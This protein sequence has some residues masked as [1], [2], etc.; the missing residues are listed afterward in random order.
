MKPKKVTIWLALVM[1]AA[2][3][4]AACAPAAP[5]PAPA[6]PTEA[7][8]E[9]PT[10]A[11]ADA[12][13]GE[14]TLAPAIAERV[15]SG[16]PLRIYVSYHD[17]SNEF[18]PFL[19]SGV[20]KAAADLGVEARFVGPVGA[21]AEQQIAELENLVESGV[22]GLAISSV[23]TDALAPIINR[24]LEQG[25]PVVTYNTDNPDSKRLAFAGQDLEQ[26]GYEA[27]KVLA[28]LLG[29]QGDV[30]ITTLDAAAQWS[31]D[32]ETGARRAFAEYPGIKVLTTVNTGT[33]PQEIYAA[34]ENAMLAN[35]TVTGVLSLEC[36]STPADGE[37]V[38]RNSLQGQV[39]VVGFDELP[40]TL[41]LIKDG[42]VAASISQAPDRQGF[43]AVR[44]L[45][46]FLKGSPIADV[47][48]GVGIINQ[49]NVD[50]YLTG[51]APAAAPAASDFVLAPAIAERVASGQPLRIYVS[52]HDVSNEFAP[53]LK[54]GVEKAAADLGV[55][56]R[57]VGPVGADAEQ[58]IAELENLVESGVD[59]LAISSVSTDALAPII[60]RFLEQGIPVVTYNT[61]NPD[62]K[63]L[64]FAGQ[65]LE[66][67]GYEA[68][69][70]LADLLGGQGDVIITTLDAAAQWSIDRETGAR[71]AFAEYP[72]IKVLTTVNTGTEPQEIYAAVEN[73]MLA[74]PTVTGVLS[75]ECCSTPADGEYVKRNSLQ[76]QVTVV[77][78]DELPATL[79]L[80]KDGYVAA[81]ISQAPDRQGFEAV[82]MLVDFL[83]GSPIADV[84][85]GVGIINQDNVDQYLK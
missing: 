74:N 80:I 3:L 42:Y 51:E 4:L 65:D 20:E 1:V 83:K 75:L 21:D 24:F 84:D 82:R 72:G 15:A 12:A 57:F 35:P 18:A 10:E 17:V 41:D 19:K 29:G 85:T 52:Y 46:D 53:F 30:I 59:G 7:A 58:Q 37:Y 63:R 16:Q 34:V 38:K 69:K 61:D 8:A 77:G 6:E 66:Q 64:A 60:N 78:F 79:D 49:D 71:R 43:E 50:Q 47:D 36:C 32:R 14:F 27:A 25:I 67:S 70:V 40:A 54:S 23:S 11:P 55:E 62:S 73:A 9:A 5:A 76:G 44:M 33:E 68:A 81:S 28:D 45:V 22:D 2:L 48:T 26:S 31:I 39:T 13:A 56:A